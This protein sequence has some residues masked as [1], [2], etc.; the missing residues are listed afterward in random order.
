MNFICET[1]SRM[2]VIFR[3]KSNE[4]NSIMIGYSDA[5]VTAPNHYLIV[6][7]NASL[8]TVLLQCYS[9]GVSFVIR[10]YLI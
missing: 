10:L 9:C 7:L 2:S 1:F 5:I 6:R 8:S 4:P 3:D